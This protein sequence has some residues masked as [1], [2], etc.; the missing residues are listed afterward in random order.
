MK[1]RL[2]SALLAAVMLLTM[3]QVSSLALDDGQT[4][5]ESDDQTWIQYVEQKYTGI[6]PCS[7]AH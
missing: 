3:P 7:T 6:L 2:L 4:P 5:V 1:K